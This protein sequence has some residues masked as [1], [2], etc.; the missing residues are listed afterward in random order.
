MTKTRRFFHLRNVLRKNNVARKVKFSLARG[1]KLTQV[2]NAGNAGEN[3]KFKCRRGDNRIQTF[4]CPDCVNN[5]ITT[6]KRHLV[7]NT[8]RVI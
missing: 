6:V 5:T 8:R 2:Y 4:C 1:F 3:R 7:Y